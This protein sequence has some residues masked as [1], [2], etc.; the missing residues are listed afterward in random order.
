[1][2]GERLAAFGFCRGVALG[3][4]GLAECTAVNEEIVDFP[5]LLGE[6]LAEDCR[7]AFRGHALAAGG[8]ARPIDVT[9]DDVAIRRSGKG[10]RVRSGGGRRGKN[11][12]RG[13]KQ[14][15]TEHRY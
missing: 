7:T 2:G 15:W 12:K 6:R 11:R 3:E 14:S 1:M 10:R 13:E 5:G 4:L 8:A 9:G